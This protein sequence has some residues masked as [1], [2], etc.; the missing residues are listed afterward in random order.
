MTRR[1][2]GKAVA[3]F[4][5][6][7][8]LANTPNFNTQLKV[9]LSNIRYVNPPIGLDYSPYDRAY[10]VI[11]RWKLKYPS[12]KITTHGIA[13]KYKDQDMQNIKLEE[14]LEAYYEM[15]EFQKEQFKLNRESI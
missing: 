12:G 5:A 6:T 11:I 9:E 7:T 3:L 14:L 2:F 4:A 13:T 10:G 15:I 8:T 1:T